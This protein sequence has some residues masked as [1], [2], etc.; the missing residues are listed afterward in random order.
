[1]RDS[2]YSSLLIA[3]KSVALERLKAIQCSELPSAVRNRLV[4][5]FSSY[6]ARHIDRISKR[7]LTV[8]R[9]SRTLLSS[10]GT[11]A[12]VV[13]DDGSKHR[14]SSDASVGVQG[15]AFALPPD[16]LGGIGL[17]PAS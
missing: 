12:S 1:M 7:F 10:L 9:V 17:P 3:L 8:P 13:G 15:E 14:K 4:E 6:A 2:N 5:D 16:E 11:A